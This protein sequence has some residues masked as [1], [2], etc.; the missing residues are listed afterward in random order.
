MLSPLVVPVV[1]ASTIGATPGRGFGLGVAVLVNEG[2]AVGG[3]DV[4]VGVGVTGVAVG[5]EVP[6]GTEVSVTGMGVY[7]GV[8]VLEGALVGV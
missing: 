1:T 3:T 4:L 7:V 6:V 2:V 5:R 8:A